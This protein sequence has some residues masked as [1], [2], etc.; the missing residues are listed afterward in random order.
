[1]MPNEID[2]FDLKRIITED[3]NDRGGVSS[4]PFS[5]EHVLITVDGTEDVIGDWEEEMANLDVKSLIDGEWSLGEP[6]DV[7]YGSI[8]L[9]DISGNMVTDDYGI[10]ETSRHRFKKMF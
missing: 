8:V 6:E 2:I 7:D 1:M 10:D 3:I 5:I 9:E 4:H